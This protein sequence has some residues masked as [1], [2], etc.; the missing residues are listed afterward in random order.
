MLQNYRATT[1][2]NVE[3]II[4]DIFEGFPISICRPGKGLLRL[5]KISKS[6]NNE[7]GSYWYSDKNEFD[8]KLICLTMQ[9]FA[10]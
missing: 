2:E 3:I 8:E 9:Q 1:T 4:L 6:S 10:G 7:K 5:V